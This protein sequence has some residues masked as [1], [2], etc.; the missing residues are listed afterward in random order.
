M[1]VRCRRK[2]LNDRAS[3]EIICQGRFK[4]SINTIFVNG[5]SQL[6]QRCWYKADYRLASLVTLQQTK[7]LSS[8][9]SFCSAERNSSDGVDGSH[10]FDFSDALLKASSTVFPSLDDCF[11]S[12]LTVAL[13]EPLFFS[14]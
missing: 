8:N 1:D 12:L 3:D 7:K 14:T 9:F 13:A 6:K 10:S 4:N 5:M 2:P 11:P